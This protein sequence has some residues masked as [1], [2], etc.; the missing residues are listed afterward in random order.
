MT[1]LVT[2]ESVTCGHPDKVCDQISDA[3]LTQI[4]KNDKNAR[5]AVET[6]VTSGLVSVMGEIS[7]DYYVEIENI[8][9][10]T[11]KKIGYNSSRVGFDYESCGVLVSID[12]QSPDI[13]QGVDQ[14]KDI[15]H[16]RQAKSSLNYLGAGDQGIMFG[17]ANCETD[18]LFPLAPKIANELALQ[19]V[20][21]REEGTVENLRPDGKTQITLEYDGKKARAVKTVVISAQHNE[22]VNEKTLKNEILKSVVR[23]VL[24]KYNFSKYNLDTSNFDFI[25]N[26]TGKFIIGGPRADTGL[27]GRKI[28]VDT[29][30]GIAHHGGGAF[31]GKDPSKVDRSASYALR[32]IA[33]NVVAA[34]LA[35]E[36]ELQVSYAIGI[37]EPVSLNIDTFGTGLISDDKILQGVKKVFDLRPAA[38]IRDLDLLNVD[39]TQ[40]SVFGH[41]GR[42]DVSFSWEEC[43]RVNELKDA[44]RSF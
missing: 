13:S 31:S 9:R 42:S 11:L 24:D 37:A 17:Y 36:V 34:D 1:R 40:T 15:D 44:C 38:I 19:L 35:K 20:K 26:P 8:V 22:N 3:I 27:T 29:Y 33:K 43:N 18:E 16:K 5:V 32:W 4:L 23:P 12:S 2:S 41:F 21:V 28:I 30:G 39:Y 25:F 6:F 14:I 10:Q 7:T